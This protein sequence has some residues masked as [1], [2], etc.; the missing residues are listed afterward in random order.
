MCVIIHAFRDFILICSKSNE[1][2]MS[3]IKKVFTI[4][5]CLYADRIGK[6]KALQKSQNIENNIQSMFDVSILFHNYY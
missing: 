5:S 1:Y 4:L 6:A 3:N 2:Q